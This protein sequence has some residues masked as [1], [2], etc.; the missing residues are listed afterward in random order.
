MGVVERR[1]R[2]FEQ[3]VRLR[4]VERRH[5]DDQDVV[6]VRAQLEHELGPV[7][8]SSMA[9]DLLGVSHTTIHRWVRAGEIPKLVAPSG[10]S[11]VPVQA[12]LRLHEQVEQERETGR[13]TGHVIESVVVDAHQKAARLHPR[14]L[15]ADAVDGEVRD[16]HERSRLR[17]L[18]YHRAVARQLRR[19]TVDEALHRIWQW[20]DEGRIDPRYAQ[21]WEEVLAQPL[22]EI[23]KVLREDSPRAD[24]LRQSSP[25]AGEL[26]EAERRKI[27]QE[28]G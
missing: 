2:L 1:R 28:V 8:S 11:G 25:F 21:R 5:P 9:A 24:D 14:E 4:R 6:A 12:L 18:A 22:P 13:R 20:R 7:V 17:S 26:S 16:R 10:R 15:V 23:R 19:T 3:V 27:L